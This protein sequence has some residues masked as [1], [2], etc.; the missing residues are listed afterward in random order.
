MTPESAF[1][2]ACSCRLTGIGE[3]A[4]CHLKAHPWDDRRDVSS[5]A[6]HFG[7]A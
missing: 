4:V 1:D 6:R 3:A 2:D 7:I 5:L